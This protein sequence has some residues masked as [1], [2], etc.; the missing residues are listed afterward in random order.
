MLDAERKSAYTRIK[1]VT[2]LLECIRRL[3]SPDPLVPDSYDVHVLR[4]LYYVHLYAAFEHSVNNGVEGFIRN[5]TKLGV[6]TTHLEHPLFSIALDS[7]LTSLKDIGE[8]KK[9][10]RRLDVFNKQQSEDECMLNDSVFG[11]YLQNVWFKSL[12]QVFQCLNIPSPAVPHPMYGLSIDEI[13]EKRNAVAHGRESPADV[14]RGTRSPELQLKLDSITTVVQ[15]MF[16]CFEN[17][18][19]SRTFIVSHHRASYA[20]T[21]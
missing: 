3:E 7:Q 20:A 10:E 17:A 9:W 14:G 21:N 2:G 4:G 19:T 1:E 13:V 12:E 18:L 8:L 15:H 6:K 16:E 5:I 11:Q